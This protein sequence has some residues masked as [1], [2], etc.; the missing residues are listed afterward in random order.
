M[1]SA[2]TT[3]RTGM[4]TFAGILF[5]LVGAFNIADG[6]VALTNASYFSDAVLIANYGF[7]GVLLLAFGLLAIAAGWAI[8][9]RYRSGQIFG[10]ALAGLNAFA[11]LLFI[12]HFPLWSVTIMFLDLLIIYVLCQHDKEFSDN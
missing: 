12:R 11:H 2:S 7:W 4:I 10:L 5:I 8:M 1:S 6:V 3:E 9:K